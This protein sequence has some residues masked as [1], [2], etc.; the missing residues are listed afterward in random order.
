MKLKQSK[1]VVLILAGIVLLMAGH[2]N[3][4]IPVDE[5]PPSGKFSKLIAPFKL[6]AR[7]PVMARTQGKVMSPGILPAGENGVLIVIR[8][9]GREIRGKMAVILREQTGD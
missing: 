4:T 7:A 9:D 2:E 3:R 5:V 1:L 8:R 6:L